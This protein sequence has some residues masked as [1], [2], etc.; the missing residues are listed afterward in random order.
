[1]RSGSDQVRGQRVTSFLHG[2]TTLFSAGGILRKNRGRFRLCKMLA[3]FSTRCIGELLE[4]TLQVCLWGL[5]II[6]M[7]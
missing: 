4:V 7:I 1:M 2:R 3:H 5:C 6:R